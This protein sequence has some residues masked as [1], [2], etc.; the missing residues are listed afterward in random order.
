[1]AS[2]MNTESAQAQPP[3]S[4]RERILSTA[5][6]LFYNDGIQATG[7]DT[8]IA[9]AGVAKASFYVHFKS[10]DALIAA[11]VRYRHEQFQ[12]WFNVQMS[13]GPKRAKSRLL[14]VIDVI[15]R[16]TKLNGFCGCAFIATSEELADANHPARR[17]AALV[18]ISLREQLAHLAMDARMRDPVGTAEAFALIIDGLLVSARMGLGEAAAKA[19]KATAKVLVE[20]G[21]ARTREGTV[22]E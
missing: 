7:I 17:E 12:H 13:G 15:E 9:E 1:M 19:A 20:A 6:H 11:S 4:A 14:F 10:K 3:R 21:A 8:I 16:F 5:S 18:K 22:I 2:S